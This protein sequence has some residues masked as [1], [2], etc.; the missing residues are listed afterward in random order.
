MRYIA[1]VGQDLLCFLDGKYVCMQSL[2]EEAHRKQLIKIKGGLWNSGTGERH[3][4]Y[5][6]A[7]LVS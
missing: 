1:V 7:L 2:P 4:V 5:F 6:I 3:G